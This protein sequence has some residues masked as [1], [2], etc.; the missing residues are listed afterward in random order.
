MLSFERM[1]VIY[2]NMPMQYTEIFKHVNNENFDFFFLFLLKT[3]VLTS[4][5]NLCFVAKQ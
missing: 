2:E 1:N 4:T 5:H 3:K